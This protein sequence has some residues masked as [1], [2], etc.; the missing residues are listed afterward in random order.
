MYASHYIRWQEA[1]ILFHLQLQDLY[2]DSQ[3]F[4]CKT[5]IVENFYYTVIK[6]IAKRLLLI[7]INLCVNDLIH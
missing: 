1:Y 4:I 6:P 3:R 7:A 5:Y 2:L